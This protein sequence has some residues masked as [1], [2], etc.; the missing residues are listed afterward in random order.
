MRRWAMLAALGVTQ[1]AM[2]QL[3]GPVPQTPQ[4]VPDASGYRFEVVTTGLDHPWSVCWLPGDAG[5]LVTERG[6]AVKRLKDGAV[7]PVKAVFPGLQ[8]IGQGGL[9]DVSLHPNFAENGLVYFTYAQGN[10]RANKTVLARGTWSDAGETP[11]ITDIA[12]IFSVAQEKG[13]GQHFG[14]RI[15]WLPDGTLLMSVGD[16]GNPPVKYEGDWIRK[17]AQNKAAHLGKVL[18]LNDDGTAAKDNPFAG[19]SG[20]APEVWT[21]GHRNIQGLAR[22]PE[23]GRVWANEHGARGGDELNLIEKG[24]NYGWPEVTYSVWYVDASRIS[25]KTSADWS[26]DPKVVWTP[27]KAPSGLCFYTGDKFP[28]WKGDLFSGALVFGEV[29]RID[30]EGD[31]IVGQERIEIEARVRDVRQ[32]PDGYL[33]VLTDE[34]DGALIRILPEQ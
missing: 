10:A 25:E 33:Y 19:E 12:V 7:Q 8:E 14:S 3:E 29:R 6:G 26:T 16:G 22:D 1:A 28:A 27:S 23:S 18:R 20:A 24:N 17:Q 11:V 4:R 32:G 30:L 15:L 13:G 21:L 31:T 34:G 5:M 2:A 9:M